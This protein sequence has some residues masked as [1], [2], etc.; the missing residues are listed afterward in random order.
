[1]TCY[2]R[3]GA[4]GTRFVVRIKARSETGLLEDMDLAGAIKYYITFR[5]PDGSSLTVEA[6][7]ERANN[8]IYWVDMDGILT[9]PGTWTM[10]ASVTYDD[11]SLVPA[12]GSILFEVIE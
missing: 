11:D 4:I 6:S 2:H 9:I 8:D 10:H 7:K 12:G 3:V 5:R 1:M